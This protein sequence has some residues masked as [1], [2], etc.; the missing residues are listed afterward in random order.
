L[1]SNFTQIVFKY[2]CLFKI[3][4]HIVPVYFWLMSDSAL[5]HSKVQP[6]GPCNRVIFGYIK[7]AIFLLLD[8]LNVMKII[9]SN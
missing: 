7:R 5:I 6:F 4:K 8:Y 9:C 3:S 1:H 2:R